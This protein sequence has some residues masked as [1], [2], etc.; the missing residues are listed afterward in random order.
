MYSTN[1]QA[2]ELYKNTVEP[3]IKEKDLT[4]ED[5]Y[6]VNNWSLGLKL[7]NESLL[8]FSLIAVNELYTEHYYKFFPDYK[9]FTISPIYANEKL[10]N[11]R[12]VTT[13]VIR[14]DGSLEAFS[15]PNTIYS[16]NNHELVE[17]AVEKIN[18]SFIDIKM[19][20]DYSFIAIKED[21]AST[22]FYGTLRSRT[23]QK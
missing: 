17:E 14:K 3:F 23:I 16:N 5:V 7:S 13:I 2:V 8:I 11:S 6:P 21:G 10:G 18:G 12:T 1:A 4:V 19:I 15:S 20:D 22:I 9:D